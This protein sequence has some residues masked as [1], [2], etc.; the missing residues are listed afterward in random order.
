ME[1]PSLCDL[2][3]SIG[4][5]TREAEQHYS[6]PVVP[7]MPSTAIDKRRRSSPEEVGPSTEL[8]LSLSLSVSDSRKPVETQ[9]SSNNNSSTITLEP[10]SSGFLIQS[11]HNAHASTGRLHE[12]GD[13]QVSS[14][15]YQEDEVSTE[16]T[17]GPCGSWT[18]KK[19]R[20]MSVV[21]PE[22]DTEEDRR[23]G[24]STTLKLCLE[25]PW[26][27]RKS[28][29]DSDVGNLSRLLIHKT[30]VK[31]HIL[32]YMSD[33]LIKHVNSNNGA[34]VRV[35]DTDSRSAHD[36]VFKLWP[37]CHS[38]VLMGKWGREFV[39]RRDLKAGDMIGLRW[40]SFSSM[41]HFCVLQRAPPP[42]SSSA[43]S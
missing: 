40:N 27:I 19:Q 11:R 12:E 31:E 43:S 32:R 7:P 9:E 15:N 16:L 36:M 20:K 33:E 37:S 38:Y 13:H 17:L 39:K 42:N 6:A 24:V 1:E 14:T 21:Y 28:L 8:T 4:G 25:D 30:T 35:W 5:K 29:R 22:E 3:L 34:S 23:C 2:G 10:V 26:K 41:F 18:T